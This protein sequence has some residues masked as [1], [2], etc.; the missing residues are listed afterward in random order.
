M[1]RQ[2]NYAFDAESRQAFVEYLALRIKQPH[3]GNARSVRNAIDRIKLRQAS[4]LVSQGG[5]IPQEQLLRIAAIDI[6]QSR[7]FQGGSDAEPE[8]IDDG[9]AQSIRREE[10]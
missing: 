5:C 1:M 8:G 9:S 10:A 6:R 3:F 7:V 2:Q 4:R